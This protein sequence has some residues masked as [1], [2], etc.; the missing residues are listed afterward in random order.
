LP[1]CKVPGSDQ[2]EGNDS[3]NVLNAQDSFL[4]DAG[5]IN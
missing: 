1:P 2:A 4:E 3:M 5:N